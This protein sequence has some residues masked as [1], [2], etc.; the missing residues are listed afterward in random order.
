WHPEANGPRRPPRPHIFL[1]LR[2]RPRRFEYDGSTGRC[3]AVRRSW[4]KVRRPNKPVVQPPTSGE[5]PDGPTGERLLPV[6]GS[7]CE[8]PAFCP[9]PRRPPTGLRRD[10]FPP[11]NAALAAF[12]DGSRPGSKTADRPCFQTAAA[13]VANRIRTSVD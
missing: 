6:V 4:P 11:R 9:C 2:F 8:S 12:L 10:G 13:R 3:C 5:T 7:T 1:G